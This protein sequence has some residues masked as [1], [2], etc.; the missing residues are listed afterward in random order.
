MRAMRMAGLALR[1]DPGASK[2]R[3]M[4][5][6]SCN[7]TVRELRSCPSLLI[8]SRVPLVVQRHR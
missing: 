3:P 5:R 2:V 8:E 6:S 7:V 4:I 1:G